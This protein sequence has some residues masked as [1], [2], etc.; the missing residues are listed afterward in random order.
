MPKANTKRMMTNQNFKTK[1]GKGT[2]I[3]KGTQA[4]IKTDLK[5]SITQIQNS[6]K[7]Y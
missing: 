3:L 5:T 7:P 2:E 1:F 6:G 4:E